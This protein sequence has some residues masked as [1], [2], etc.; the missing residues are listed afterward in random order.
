M[1]DDTVTVKGSSGEKV[2]QVNGEAVVKQSFH[3]CIVKAMVFPVVM[4]VCK[5]MKSE[6]H[7]VVSDSLRPHGLYSA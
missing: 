5:W 7:S 4:Y 1:N 3:I 2:F 6:S